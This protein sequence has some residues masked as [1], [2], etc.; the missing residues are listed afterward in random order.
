M[1][2]NDWQS[3]CTANLGQN[4]SLY[5]LPPRP[6]NEVCGDT[7][8]TPCWVWAAQNGAIMFPGWFPGLDGLGLQ[9]P[10]GS[11][12]F[13]QPGHALPLDFTMIFITQNVS[14]GWG[15][16]GGHSRH[17]QEWC[18][19]Q[20]STVLLHPSISIRVFQVPWWQCLKPVSLCKANSYFLILFQIHNHSGFF[21][22]LTTHKDF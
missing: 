12:L 9:C 3:L 20:K 11:I 13:K 19:A 4:I 8:T 18:H 5:P 14:S 6:L 1:N 7:C 21:V 2:Q 16:F 10:W 17:S 22:I 15:N